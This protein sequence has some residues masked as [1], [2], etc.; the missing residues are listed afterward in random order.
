MR[1]FDRNQPPEVLLEL[2]IA[3]GKQSQAST[4]QIGEL[5]TILKLCGEDK[6]IP[7]IVWQ[8]LHPLLEWHRATDRLVDDL[9]KHSLLAT[10]R[11][12][13]ALVPRIIDRLLARQQFS[14]KPIAAVREYMDEKK[15]KEAETQVP[16]V[17]QVIEAVA[18]GINT[19]ADDLESAVA[20][21]T[22]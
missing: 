15:W 4:A 7:H 10:S 5:L 19:A 9:N 16:Q 13:S 22:K 12:I 18:A 17:S 14:A 3:I 20:G 1:L 2:A 21:K 11:N 8:N 6:L